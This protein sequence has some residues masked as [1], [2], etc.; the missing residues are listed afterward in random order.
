MRGRESQEMKEMRVER[1]FR[2]KK[3]KGGNEEENEEIRRGRK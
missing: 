1:E 3:K 2:E